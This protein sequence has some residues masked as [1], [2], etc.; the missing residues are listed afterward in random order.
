M[1]DSSYIAHPSAV[2]DDGARIGDGTRIWH[3]SHI[4][5]SA[6]I[7]RDCTIGQNC[8]I[9]RGVRIGSGVKIQNNVS[10]YTG[11]TVEDYAFLGPSCVFT[12]VPTPRSGFS[13]NNPEVDFHPIHVELGA[14]VGANSTVRA[15]VTLGKWCLI[16]AG[17][18]ITHD[19]LP[20]AVMT[21]V[22]ARQTGWACHCGAVL[23]NKDGNLECPEP[24]CGRSYVEFG[25]ELRL[26]NTPKQ[27]DEV[28]GLGE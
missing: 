26:V 27:A 6:V 14:S 3:F 28:A 7:G 18:V 23:A 17:A 8:Y 5:S 10:V 13:R 24:R 22:P 4:C 1:G 9:D 15:G 20:H 2:I 19:V 12:N 11:V 25:D 16:G 21:G